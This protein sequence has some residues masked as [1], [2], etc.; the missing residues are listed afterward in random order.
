MNIRFSLLSVLL[1]VAVIGCAEGSDV[2]PSQTIPDPPPDPCV[3]TSY[4]ITA[5]HGEGKFKDWNWGAK[6]CLNDQPPKH[7]N[8]DTGEIVSRGN[9]DGCVDFSNDKGE[10]FTCCP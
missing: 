9:R 8:P 7:L 5:C 6:M 2:F 3:E 1:S 10:F 4:S